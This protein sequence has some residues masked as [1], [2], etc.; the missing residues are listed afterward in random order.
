VREAATAL[1]L[2]ESI[3]FAYVA[4]KELEGAGFG[5]VP[6]ARIA[7][8]LSE[9]RAILRPSL[10]PRLLGA[11]GHAW[12]HGEPRVRLFEVGT[13]FAPGGKQDGPGPLRERT[14]VAFVLAGPRD[15]YLGRAED[16]D[17]FD[18]KGLV[19]A[20]V[21]RLCGTAIGLHTDAP[22]PPWAHPRKF[23]HVTVEGTAV[24]TFAELHP[25][26]RA[27]LELPRG[28]VVA[29]LEGA[30]LA[31]VQRLPVAQAPAKFPSVRRDVALLVS[32]AQPAGAIAAL[33]QQQA[34][35]LCQRVELFDRYVG[36]ELPEGT[37]SLAFALWFRSPER[38]LTDEQV[39]T[40][41]RTALAAVGETFGARQR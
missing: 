2:D 18:A 7:N 20:L 10:L 35:A 36:P 41:T 27:A 11:V 6:L 25:D 28:A 13:V 39:E 15:V 5:A 26:V 9:D 8:P 38:T 19:E 12:R 37:H 23:A 29:E 32:R 14:Q 16:V 3:S 34:G 22:P 30:P 4:S 21:R 1:G 33:L 31:A 24:G 17:F 40:A